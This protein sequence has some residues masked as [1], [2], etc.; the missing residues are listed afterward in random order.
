MTEITG[1]RRLPWTSLDGKRQ[2]VQTDG[3]LATVADACEHSMVEAVKEDV[4]RALGSARDEDSCRAELREAIRFLSRATEDAIMVAELRG[5]RLPAE[6][7]MTNS[8][9]SEIRET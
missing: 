8:T 4:R 1:L 2:Y 6:E 3:F 5:E 9:I 7:P